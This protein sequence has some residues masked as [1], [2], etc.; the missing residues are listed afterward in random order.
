MTIES[1]LRAMSGAE[2]DMF[3]AVFPAGRNPQCSW[4]GDHFALLGHTTRPLSV[5][6]VESRFLAN[7]VALSNVRSILEIG[8]GFGYSTAW[9]AYGLGLCN[10]G[11]L[12]H[13]VDDLSEGDVGREASHAAEELW[14][15]T[16]VSQRI[17][18]V[19]GRSPD[20]LLRRPSVRADIA[21]IDGGHH[22]GQPILDYQAVGR[23]LVDGGCILFHDAQSK[24][25][26]PGA[27]AR[28]EMDG[29]MCLELGTSCEMVAAVSTEEQKTICTLALST[30][31]RAVML[32]KTS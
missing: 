19:R 29:Y 15:R 23:H 9:L 5:S 26:V 12:V 24:Y 4:D 28:A 32:G 20:I 1:F 6:R 18:R 17:V 3:E 30:A 11:G 31:R 25:D 7:F 21:F 22:H 13:T 2:S 14:R 10:H 16:G 27:V 8:T